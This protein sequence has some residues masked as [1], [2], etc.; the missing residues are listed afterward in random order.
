[1]EPDQRGSLDI[2][3]QTGPI[4]NNSKS[5]DNKHNKDEL[6]SQKKI[7]ISP[8]DS[9][10]NTAVPP[11]DTDD[12]TPTHQYSTPREL[13]LLSTVFTIATFMIAIDGSILGKEV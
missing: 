13:S 10:S 5:T 2:T 1:M 6:H 9:E 3:T 7:E 11:L 8:G 12:E 4:A